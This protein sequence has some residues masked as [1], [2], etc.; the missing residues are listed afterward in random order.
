MVSR[1]RR[2]GLAAHAGYRRRAAGFHGVVDAHPAG[3]GLAGHGAGR[4]RGRAGAPA[5]LRLAGAAG[6]VAR[7]QPGAGFPAYAGARPDGGAGH[8]AG[9][10][11][12]APAAPAGRPGAE[13]GPGRR[14]GAGLRGR[15]P[16]TLSRSRRSTG[17]AALPARPRRARAGHAHGHRRPASPVRGARRAAGLAAQRGHAMGGC[18]AVHQAATHRRASRN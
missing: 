16:G 15:R 11:R 2:A 18:R 17:I 13:P 7:T 5:G 12:R 14:R 3:A 4:P 8:R 10:R 1:R 9:R 6:A